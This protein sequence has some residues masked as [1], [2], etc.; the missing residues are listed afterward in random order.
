MAANSVLRPISGVSGWGT[1]K[2]GRVEVAAVTVGGAP[3]F[4]SRFGGTNRHDHDVPDMLR[5][6]GPTM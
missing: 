1:A 2:C 3:S 6:I 5:Q 4:A